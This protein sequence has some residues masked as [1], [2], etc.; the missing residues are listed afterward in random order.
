LNTENKNKKLTKSEKNR[1]LYVAQFS[2][3]TYKKKSLKFHINLLV[4]IW[5][6]TIGKNDLRESI[7]A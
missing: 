2:H 5:E 7:L 3:E 4:Y 1:A 6:M